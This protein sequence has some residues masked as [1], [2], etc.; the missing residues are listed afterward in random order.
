MTSVL[1]I[2]PLPP[3][4]GGIGTW[5]ESMVRLAAATPAFRIDVVDTAPRWRPVHDLRRWRRVVYGIGQAWHDVGG[6]LVR[7]LRRRPDVV[8]LTT[9]GDLALARDACI[10]AL[11]RLLR[12]RSVYHLHF[13]WLP[14]TARAGGMERAGFRLTLSLCDTAVVL[15][16]D[17]A[18]AVAQIQPS[19][20]VA[21]MPHF[22]DA[23]E[24]ASAVDLRPSGAPRRLRVLY[25]GW[26]TDWKGMRELLT[27]CAALA[28]RHDFELTLAGPCDPAYLSMLQDLA[29]PNAAWLLPLGEIPRD[30]I[31]AL[32]ETADVF[33]LPSHSEGFPYVILEAMS[34]SRAI[35]ATRVGAIPQM[36][37]DDEGPAAELVPPRDSGAL[38]RAME[39]VLTDASLRAS[40]GKR[41]RRIVELRFT[42]EAVR[43]KYLVLWKGHPLGH[44]A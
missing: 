23:S 9:S 29:G 18:S 37:S 40:L 43:G 41:A 31:R 19:A 1:L 25:A 38:E 26:V 12:L 33:V 8:H 7:A 42:M 35:V 13:G 34:M 32:M 11:A 21:L 2:A 28:S 10:L 20:A 39:R 30:R 4:R 5:T 24:W 14:A 17:A 22:I 36:V 16:A 3:P 44:G 15:D 6:F 27:A